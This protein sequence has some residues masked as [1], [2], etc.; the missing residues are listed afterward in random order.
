ML[1]R[2]LVYLFIWFV[3]RTIRRTYLN[4]NVIESFDRQGQNYI[5]CLWHNGIF[6]F[7]PVLGPLGYAGMISRSKDGEDVAWIAQRFGLVPVRGS[8]KE[9]GA[10]ALREMIRLLASGRNVVITPDGPKGPR[11]EMKPGVTALA[12]KRKVPIIPLAFSAPNRWEFNTWDRMKVPKP[13]SR[14]VILAGA[15]FW[16]ASEDD[17]AEGLKLQQ[18]MRELVIQADQF[19]G[20]AVVSPDPML[21]AGIR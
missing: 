2:F 14:T 10:T 4:W 3:A 8:P 6:Y 21:G 9:G 1:K 5:L 13:F 16:V 7:L 15:P 18:A 19:S 12:R 17:A 11:Y 20:A